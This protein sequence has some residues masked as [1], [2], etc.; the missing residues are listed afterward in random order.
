MIWTNLLISPL[1][2]KEARNLGAMSGLA[3][4]NSG[5]VVGKFHAVPPTPGH[6]LDWGFEISSFFISGPLFQEAMVPVIPVSG[7]DWIFE[8]S[9]FFMF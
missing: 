8:I 6:G 4:E 1:V 3:T 9:S 5:P 2:A 7:M